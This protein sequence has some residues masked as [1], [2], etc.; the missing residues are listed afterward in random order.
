[1]MAKRYGPGRLI[2][3][4]R[5]KGEHHLAAVLRPTALLIRVVFANVQGGKNRTTIGSEVQGKNT[6]RRIGRR[7]VTLVD[8]CRLPLRS[9][10][11]DAAGRNEPTESQQ[12]TR[13]EGEADHAE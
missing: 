1:M 3:A 2:V 5:V 11:R 7:R 8:P 6:L 10:K 12:T 4:H 9:E 13:K